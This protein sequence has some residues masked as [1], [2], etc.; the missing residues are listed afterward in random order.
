MN[1]FR[2]VKIGERFPSTGVLEYK[3]DN[4]CILNISPDLCRYYKSLIPKSQPVQPQMYP[5]HITVVRSGKETPLNR[6]AWGRYD[7][8]VVSFE[9][10]NNVVQSG[11]YYTINAW[12]ERLEEIREE[13]GLPRTRVGFDEFHI[14]IGN[15]KNL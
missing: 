7:N 11:P 15:V 8:E 5:C 4:R 2:L 12:S 9:Y 13:L 1:W 3:G 6:E 14:T 10:D